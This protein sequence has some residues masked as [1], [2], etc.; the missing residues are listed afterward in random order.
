MEPVRGDRPRASEGA[1]LAGDLATAR[2]V[3]HRLTPWMS[4]AF[5]ESNPI[6][7]KAAMAAQ[8]RIAYVL[9]LPLVPLS[10]AHRPAVLAALG[11]AGVTLP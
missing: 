9:R 3:H 4:A 5:V 10:D 6:P 1:A 11:A 2:A 8:G 7:V